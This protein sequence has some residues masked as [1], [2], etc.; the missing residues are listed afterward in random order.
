MEQTAVDHTPVVTVFLRNRGEVLLLERSDDVGSYPGRWGGVAGH[1]EDDPEASACR[2]IREETG[3]S[4]V[5]ISFVRAGEPFVVEDGTDGAPWRVHPFLFD[6]YERDVEPNWETKRFEWVPPPAIRNR[7]T[8]PNLW[9]SYEC[10]RPTVDTIAADTDHGSSTLSVR[11]F[12]VIR[13]EVA[14]RESTTT[15]ADWLA[16]LASDLVASRPSMTV[17]ETRLNRLCADLLATG[18]APQPEPRPNSLEPSAVIDTAQAAIE[19]ASRVDEEAAETA[20]QRT[21]G[22]RVATLS[23]SATVLHALERGDPTA[24]L[25][26]ESRPGREGVAVAERL[27]DSVSVTLTSDAGIADAFA[28]WQP[29]VFVVGAD[30]ILPDGGVVN[31]VGTRGAALAAAHEGIDVLVVASTDKISY[32]SAVDRGE[33][34]PAELYDGEAEID[35]RNPTFDLT[36]AS[37]IDAIATERG[38]L[39]TDDIDAIARD[40]ED[41]ADW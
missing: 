8:V 4:D 13:D 38:W 5:A 31:K 36:P 40:H 20:T 37:V 16:S 15:D 28:T 25:L 7:E 9:Q 35:R 3:L 17:L 22:A 29:D 12:E 23:R 33:G 26:P 32:R 34:D 19:R 1:V 10:V 6:A 30:T 18:K 27:S 21:D 2:E 24:V 41:M 39:N 11:A 14:A